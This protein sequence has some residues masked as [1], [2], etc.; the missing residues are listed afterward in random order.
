MQWWLMAERHA[1][2]VVIVGPTAVGKTA[3]AIHI[4]EALGG[5]IVS[6]DSRQVYRGMDIGTAKPTVEERHRVPH[7]LVDILDPDQELTLAEFQTLACSAIEDVHERGLLPLL[8]GGTGQ[9][10]RAVIHGWGIPHVPPQPTL[11]A[12]L[13]TFADVY[14]PAVLHA[15]LAAVDPDAAHAIDSRNVR[16]VVRALEVYLETGSPISVLQQRRPPPYRILQ[17][18]LTRPRAALYARIDE[19]I[20][21]MIA[22]GLVDEVRRLLEAG[23]DWS[24]SSMRS[25]GYI[26]LSPYL[27]GQMTLEECV[28]AIR[29][30]TRRFVH[31]QATWFR[32]DDPTI[33]WFDAGQASCEAIAAVVREWLG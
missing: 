27:N 4:A 7:H 14:G 9:Y 22:G 19:R 21:Q 31:Q 15:W 33:Y 5:E 28:Q 13:E 1:P 12:D 18:G 24:L 2:L 20:D 29:R 10:V 25:L 8:V 11:R 17:I 6:A 23:Y 26:Q 32:L 30:D 3:A 16:R